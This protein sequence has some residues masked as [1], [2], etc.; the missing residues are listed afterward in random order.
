M[1]IEIKYAEGK[2]WIQESDST[3]EFET[4]IKTWKFV[5]DKANGFRFGL[6]YKGLRQ[7]KWRVSSAVTLKIEPLLELVKQYIREGNEV[8]V[9]TPDIEILF[10]KD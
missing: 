6:K 1:N 9:L 5:N 4:E 3:G 8:I 2:F 10:F 7:R